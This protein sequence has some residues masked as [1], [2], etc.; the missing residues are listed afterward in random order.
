MRFEN[1]EKF[2]ITRYADKNN[3]EESTDTIKAVIAQYGYTPE[4]VDFRKQVGAVIA[5]LNS[6]LPNSAEESSAPIVLS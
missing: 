4:F 1:K 6:L 3:K 2:V 5:S